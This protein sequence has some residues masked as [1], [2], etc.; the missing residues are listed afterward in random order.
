MNNA[1]GRNRHYGSLLFGV[2]GLIGLAGLWELLAIVV[3]NPGLMPPLPRLATALAAYSSNGEL[4]TD[5]LESIP[6]A[7]VATAIALPAGMAL[8]L[9]FVLRPLAE[10]L[11][12]WPLQFLRSLPPVALLPLLVLW[13][14]IGWQ[15]KLFAAATVAMFP[16]AVTAIQGGHLI[17]RQYGELGRDLGL[18]RAQYVRH[19]LIPGTMPYVVPGLR[20][21]SA[22]SFIMTFVGELAGASQGLGYR[23]SVSQLAYQADLMIVALVLLGLLALLTDQ[24]LAF[25]SKW[26]FP[27]AG[28]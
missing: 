20:L 7:W 6:R 3:A 22:T 10:R 16:I 17:N 14:G 4:A 12:D 21:G 5:L 8:G 18:T 26:L 11:L 23:I 28:R 15:A 25:G 19:I 13:F 9:L 1:L 24:V 2:L 27:Y